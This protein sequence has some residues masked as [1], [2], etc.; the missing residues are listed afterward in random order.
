MEH[1]MKNRN[2]FVLGDCQSDLN[3]R[4]AFYSL[5]IFSHF[6][7]GTFLAVEVSIGDI[8]DDSFFVEFIF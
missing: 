7:Q 2:A 8:I 1:L 6:C 3:E 4:A 5:L